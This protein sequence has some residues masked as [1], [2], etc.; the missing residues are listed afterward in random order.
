MCTLSVW[1]ALVTLLI[2]DKRCADH[3]EVIYLESPVLEPIPVLEPCVELSMEF[4]NMTGHQMAVLAFQLHLTASMAHDLGTS[5]RVGC[6]PA[7][8]F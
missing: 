1:P 8:W 6:L 5:S 2:L 4:N 7:T 3:Q